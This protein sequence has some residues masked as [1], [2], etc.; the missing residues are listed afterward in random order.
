MILNKTL[1]TD[2]GIF[3]DLFLNPRLKIRRTKALRMNEP[4]RKAPQ[5]FE[6]TKSCIEF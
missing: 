2:K 3:R 6:N 1:F 5:S 4:F